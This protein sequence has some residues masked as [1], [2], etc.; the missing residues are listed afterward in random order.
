[1]GAAATVAVAVVAVTALA[2]P[3]SPPDPRPSPGARTQIA[4]ISAARAVPGG[5]EVE[6]AAYPPN[7][8]D[9]D[10]CAM[11]YGVTGRP[12]RT[13]GELVVTVTGTMVTPN[14]TP[15]LICH[16]IGYDRWIRLATDERPETVRDAVSGAVFRLD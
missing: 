16:S 8:R 2:Q 11:A 3:A 9:A 1:M 13:P 12:G 15:D 10:P 7:R 6:F 4:P 14:P 5:V